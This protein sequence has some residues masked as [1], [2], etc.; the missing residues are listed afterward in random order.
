LCFG[1]ESE[2]IALSDVSPAGRILLSRPLWTSHV[3]VRPSVR[4]EVI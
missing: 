3:A 2:T 4:S 1:G